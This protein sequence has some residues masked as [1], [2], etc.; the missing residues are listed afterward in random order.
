ME[1]SVAV[2]VAM[3]N[4]ERYPFAIILIHWLIA[5]AIGANLIIGWMLDDATELLDLHRTLGM[6]ILVL[7]VFRLFF[8]F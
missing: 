8:G 4:S 3:K 1:S 7:A 2:G 6:V 5:A